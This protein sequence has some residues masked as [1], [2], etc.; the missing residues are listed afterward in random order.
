MAAIVA[1]NTARSEKQSLQIVK[2]RSSIVLLLFVACTVIA[3]GIFLRW[4]FKRYWP[5]SIT[6]SFPSATPR[7]V[8]GGNRLRLESPAGS[9]LGLVGTF[10]DELRA[11]LN[12]EYLRSLKHVDVRQVLLTATETHSGPVYRIYLLLENDL[13]TATPYVAE[14][15]A[16]RFI[17]EY[18]LVFATRAQVEQA[19]TQTTLFIA[20]YGKP[21]KSKLETLPPDKLTANVSK[22]ILFKAKTDRRTREQLQPLPSGDQARDLAA[23]IIA[24]AQFYSV[25]LD[26]FLG[27]GAMENNYLEV[28]GDLEHKVWKRRAQPGDIVLRRSRGR[29]LVLNYSIGVWQITRETLRYAHQLYLADE[30]DYSQLPERLRPSKDLDLDKIDSHVLTTYAGLLLRDL[31]E[32][33]G[34]DVT[35]AIGAY[36]GG[37]NNPNLMYAEGVSTVANYARNVLQQAALMNGR[38]IAHTRLVI[39]RNPQ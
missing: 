20:A 19:Q 15:Q 9:L 16:H 32:R 14:L 25:P 22:F 1:G 12:F 29:V 21:L 2:R 18:D 6:I 17:S 37:P 38:T 30:R 10:S 27:V 34:G 13:L 5:K 4:S 8:V 23:D 7:P 35:K 24:V 26:F 33:F 36:N 31:L 3:L 11:Y 39:R 28:R